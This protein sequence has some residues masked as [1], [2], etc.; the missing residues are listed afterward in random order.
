VKE[1]FRPAIEALESK[2]KGLSQQV[3]ETKRMINELCK[4][5]DVAPPYQDTTV[6]EQPA[7]GSL[8]ADQFYGKVM[9][10]AAR[11][12]LEMRKASNRGPAAPREIYK[13]L[14]L[15]GFPF[16]TKIETNAIAGL[17][18]TLRKNSSI[19]HRLPNG[20]YGLLAWYPKAKAQD[21]DA[22]K[23]RRSSKRPN[24]TPKGR[25]A[26]T[27]KRAAQDQP[28][29]VKEAKSMETGQPSDGSAITDRVLDAM[30]DGTN[31][32]IDR[33]KS[34]A[35]D[36]AAVGG[37]VLQGCF[38]SLKSR[39]L[40]TQ[41]GKGL[42]KIAGRAREPVGDAGSADIVPLKGAAA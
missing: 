7:I 1:E 41:V 11:E 3:A 2:L 38:I 29:P 15:G 13:A 23:S 5:A 22:P 32:S 6:Q 9:T 34:E 19:F 20:E 16:D 35:P 36:V 40:I 31:W 24:K 30:R 10:T 26:P 25:K 21:D 12:Y 33:L 39:G 18:Q 28:A 4:L 37:R 14:V 8:R 42:W 17:R 27:D